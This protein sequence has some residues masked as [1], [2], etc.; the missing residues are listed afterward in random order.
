LFAAFCDSNVGV[1]NGHTHLKKK[2]LHCYFSKT[3]EIWATLI[4]T[5]PLKS[6]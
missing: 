1:G 3:L 4:N 5:S 2:E 6:N